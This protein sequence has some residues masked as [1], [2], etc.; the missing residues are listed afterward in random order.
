MSSKYSFG[1][2][3]KKFWLLVIPAVILS[4]FIGGILGFFLVDKVIM[5]KFTD[6]QNKN[7]VEV[8]QITGL[9]VE[10]AAQIAYD[11]GLRIIKKDKEYSN[12]KPVNSVI[13]QDP[14]ASERVKKGRHIFVTLSNGPEVGTIPHI[15]K[16]AEGPA[17]S[18]LR[19][20]GFE[21]IT[22]GI[23]YDSKI[24]PQFAIETNPPSETKT[25]R[26]VPVVLYLS[27]GQRPTHATVPNLVGEMFSQAQI[28]IDEKGLKLGKVRYEVSSVMAAGQVILQ[29][30]TPGNDVPLESS[31][32]VVVAAER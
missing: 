18:A 2:S 21:N 3:V 12:T 4:L 9:D 22:V 23:K 19:Q 1:I 13:S 30:L 20:A 5:P 29:S 27:K 17:K 6:L 16:L 31:I 15:E 14:K 28:T 10:S 7:D 11:L 26:E 8:P 32:D 24:P 25:S